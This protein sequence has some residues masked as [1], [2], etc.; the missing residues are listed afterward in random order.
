MLAA[1]EAGT[2]FITS[3]RS[4][5]TLISTFIIIIDRFHNVVFV[6]ASVVD[7]IVDSAKTNVVISLRNGEFSR[8]L[9]QHVQMTGMCW[10][11]LIVINPEDDVVWW[12]NH[13]S[14]TGLIVLK[15]RQVMSL[16]LY[17]I[18]GNLDVA[19]ILFS[20]I[21]RFETL[22][23]VIDL[24]ENKVT[25]LV[26]SSFHPAMSSSLNFNWWSDHFRKLWYI[27]I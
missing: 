11:L 8:K 9:R 19:I 26:K 2:V 21:W 18:R 17:E 13:L 1:L 7:H 25:W 5:L 22:L 24:L 14:E 16:G 27:K 23:C 6:Q 3:F 10:V 15:R 12:R 20:W 4:I